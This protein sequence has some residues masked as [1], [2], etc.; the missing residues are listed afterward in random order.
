M[1]AL[2]SAA[3][4]FDAAPVHTRVDLDALAEQAPVRAAV[5]GLSK[6]VKLSEVVDGSTGSRVATEIIDSEQL[7]LEVSKPLRFV[8]G[9]DGADALLRCGN[10]VVAR[11]TEYTSALATSVYRAS[12]RRPC[13]QANQDR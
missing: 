12:G 13:P 11:V 9:D 7:L 10:E 1:L 6:R 2:L 4:A 5:R 3:A 8:T